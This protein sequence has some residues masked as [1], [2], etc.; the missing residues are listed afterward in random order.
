[1][2]GLEHHD[3]HD[4]DFHIMVWR[5]IEV[6]GVRGSQVVFTPCASYSFK[7][8]CGASVILGKTVIFLLNTNPFWREEND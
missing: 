6:K 4:G 2:F 5:D 1:M 7:V 8:I 3:L